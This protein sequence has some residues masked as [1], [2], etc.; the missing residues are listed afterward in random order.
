MNPHTKSIGKRT[1]YVTTFTT[2]PG[3]VLDFQ[4]RNPLN[5]HPLGL[6]SPERVGNYN[7]EFKERTETSGYTVEITRSGDG[8]VVAERATVGRFFSGKCIDPRNE[9]IIR[10]RLSLASSRILNASVQELREK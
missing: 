8:S 5:D 6:P 10:L 7:L 1:A 2:S 9:T 4:S 3:K